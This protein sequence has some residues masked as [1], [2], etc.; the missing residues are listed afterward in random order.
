[1]GAGHVYVS[2]HGRP[3][4]H[5]VARG[6]HAAG[7]GVGV[8]LLWRLALSEEIQDTCNFL[9]SFSAAINCHD[10]AEFRRN[11]HLSKL[12]ILR[13]AGIRVL[14]RIRYLA[15]KWLDADVF[16]TRAAAHK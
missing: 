7:I 3:P 4:R 5:S 12:W 16:G 6:I 10:A 9:P 2:A 8:D 15:C 14:G 11:G 1:M 13:A